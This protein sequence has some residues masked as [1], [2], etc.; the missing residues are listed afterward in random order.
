LHIPRT[1][2]AVKAYKI[3]APD[4]FAIENKGPSS[5]TQPKNEAS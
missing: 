4:G 3:G 5:A 2:L 1:E